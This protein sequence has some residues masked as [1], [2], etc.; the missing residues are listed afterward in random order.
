M[1]FQTTQPPGWFKVISIILL[2]WN[3]MGVASFIFHSFL[4]TGEALE[5]LPA[6]EQ[7]LYGEYPI[8]T[9]I[10]FGIAVLSALMA[11]IFLLKKRKSARPFFIISLLAI[12]VQMYHN[13]FMTSAIDVYGPQTYIM[14]VFVIIIAIFSVWFTGFA[15][16]KNWLK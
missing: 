11:S 6:K 5:K 4:M 13:V 15:I 10:V 1:N 2:V 12:L 7:A 14:P 16:K 8:W 3:L 9:K